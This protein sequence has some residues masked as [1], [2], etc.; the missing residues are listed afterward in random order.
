MIQ[1]IRNWCLK[2]LLNAITLTDV[3]EYKQGN[4]YIN[5]ALI[6]VEE[7]Q[8]ITEEAKFIQNTR[9]WHLLQGTLAEQAKENIFNKSKNI[10][11]IMFGKATLYAIDLQ[12]KII[13]K[14]RKL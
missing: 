10:D 5:N 1:R 3:I 14:L 13:D 11:D 7:L 2:H 4:F 8:S 12:N 9:I 6:S